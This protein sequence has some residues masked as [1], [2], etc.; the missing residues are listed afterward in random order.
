LP[1]IV[2]K[3][4]M[5]KLLFSLVVPLLIILLK[6]MGMS[7]NQSIVLGS[8]FLTI[9]WWGT[10][11]VYKDAASVFLIF[12]FIL[13][14]RTPIEKVFFFPLSDNFTLVIASYLI[15]QGIV[16]SKV[17][18]KFSGY[19]L[20]RYCYNSIRL[21]IMSF[22]IGV[23]LIFVIPQPF[24]RII[25]LASIYIN[26]LKN[27]S[28]D[29]E[30]KMILIFSVFVASTVTS[31]MFLNGDV[32]INYAAMKFGG[33]NLT[34]MEWVKYMTL[35]TIVATIVIAAAFILIFKKDLKSTFERTDTKEKLHFGISEKKALA[36]TAVIILLWLTES[37]HGISAA[38]VAIIGVVAMFIARIIS[39]KDFKV[40]NVS[41]LIFLTAEFSIG[42][43]LTESGVAH[44]IS[45]FI[46][47]Y[48]PAASSILYIPFIILL[49]M[50]LH[51]IMGSLV[52]AV[53]VLIPTLVAITA[54]SLSS[55]FVVML[56][57]ASICF[58]Y[59][60][61][62]HHVSIMIGYGNGYYENKHTIKMGVALTFITIIVVLL[63]YVPWWK[64]MGVM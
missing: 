13:F 33:I 7:L 1:Q 54:G 21:A 23:L 11:I 6:P 35:P 25:L 37:K 15:S 34:Y 46:T 40:I 14:G 52:T 39:L 43:V 9:I 47:G 62:F 61:P 22:V 32:I 18:D 10:G 45:E 28:V 2:K 41:L 51:M 57:L 3:E 27:T 31:L 24:P 48:F 58:H 20:Q 8:L 19:I 30:E 64:L 5:P 50:I 26:F 42:K 16:N 44:R 59:I 53:S 49:V 63:I 4:N 29:K 38:N 55:Q 12:M 17:A 56:A 60:L 36:I